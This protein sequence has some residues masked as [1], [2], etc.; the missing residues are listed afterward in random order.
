MS[1]ELDTLYSEDF[2]D[3]EH[4]TLDFDGHIIDVTV[5][6]ANPIPEDE[7][8]SKWGSQDKNDPTLI[9]WGMRVNYAR[10]VLK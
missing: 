7:I 3:G 4:L 10:R 5:G 9:N 6:K 1:L 2:E 8:I